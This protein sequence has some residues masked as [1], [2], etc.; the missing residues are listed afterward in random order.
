MDLAVHSF[1]RNEKVH[2]FSEDILQPYTAKSWRN[3]RGELM[4]KRENYE[5]R[6]E[7]LLVPIADA[8]HVEIFV[9]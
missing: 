2:G 6:T 4:S 7:E 5:T 8:N 9:V 3:S 1:L